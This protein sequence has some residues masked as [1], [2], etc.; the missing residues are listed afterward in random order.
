M[1]TIYANELQEIWEKFIP[2]SGAAD[3]LQGEML[4]VLEKIQFELQ[5]NGMINWNEDFDYFC[6][7]LIE[8]LQKIQG[9]G[10]DQLDNALS[11][12]RKIK[13]QGAIAIES[14]SK[15]QD[16]PWLEDGAA[17]Q[18][19]EFY[20]P[21]YDTIGLFYKNNPEKITYQHARAI[22]R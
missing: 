17:M 7:F 14:N 11:A 9:D 10:Y 4:R 15:E 18:E 8:N 20:T 2:K 19:D 16:M 5:D 12:L 13:A 6:D 21:V 3:S 1:K 22:S